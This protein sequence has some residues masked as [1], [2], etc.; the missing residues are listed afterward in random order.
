MARYRPARRIGSDIPGH[1][2]YKR[3]ALEDEKLNSAFFDESKANDCHQVKNKKNKKKK[4][5]KKS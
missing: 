1:W 2:D 3:E 4:G 5:E